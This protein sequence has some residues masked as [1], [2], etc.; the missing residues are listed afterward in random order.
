MIASEIKSLDELKE[1]MFGI[2]EPI[3]PKEFPK[4]E[5]DFVIVPGIAFDSDLYRLG[6]GK[7]YYDKF[8]SDISPFK[9]GICKKELFLERL[10]H[11]KYDVKMDKFITL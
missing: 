2:Y 10:P 8:L 5:I 7:G 1:G 4:S 11:D 3:N 6:Y 9:L